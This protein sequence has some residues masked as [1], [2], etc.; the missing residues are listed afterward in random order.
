[1][2]LNDKNAKVILKEDRYPEG[3]NSPTRHI[4]YECPCGR[5]KIIDERVLGFADYHAYIDCPDC[6]KKYEINCG[7]GH[8]WELEEK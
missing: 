5:G 2:K 3:A 4:E 8:I 7:C 1:M 6:E